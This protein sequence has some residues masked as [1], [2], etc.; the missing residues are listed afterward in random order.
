[1]HR[2]TSKLF[3]I[4]LRVGIFLFTPYRRGACTMSIVMQASFQ[5][6]WEWPTASDVLTSNIDK[7]HNRFSETTHTRLRGWPDSTSRPGER[8]ITRLQ[9]STG[10]R[11]VQC[12]IAKA[13]KWEAKFA[14]RSYPLGRIPSKSIVEEMT[15]GTKRVCRN[16]GS[17][18]I[19]YVINVVR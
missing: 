8:G 5:K 14:S 2:F 13:E 12:P 15:S 7:T 3:I 19:C 16:L 10:V 1:M 4:C 18:E 9:T 17:F 6:R 11:I